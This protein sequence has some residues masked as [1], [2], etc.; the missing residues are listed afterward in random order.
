MFH[1]ICP[2]CGRE[3]APTVRECPVCDPV[4]ARVETA[5]AGE[6]EAPARAGLEAEAPAIS[7]T[8][9]AAETKPESTPYQPIRPEAVATLADTAADVRSP[10]DIAIHDI[11]EVNSTTHD[12][13]TH[14]STTHDN[15]T[16][17]NA[18][19]DSALQVSTIH[20]SAVHDSAVHDSAPP[21]LAARV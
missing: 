17:D 20:D 11:A 13:T 5:L 8:G 15:A 9:Q 21:A 10:G 3:I 1:W 4:A 16:H 18:E 7:V 6:V 19:V 12:S 14:D 2:E